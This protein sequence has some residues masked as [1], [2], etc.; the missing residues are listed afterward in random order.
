MKS[1]DPVST[2]LIISVPAEHPCYANHFPGNPLVP[3][4]LLLQWILARAEQKYNCKI[5]ELKSIKFLAPVKPGDDLKITMNTNPRKN[6][7]SFDIFVI[8][9]LVIK[10]SIEHDNGKHQNRD[11]E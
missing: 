8:D 5:I 4:A 6:Q 3:G 2:E 10:G 11:H 7:L 9:K 1:N